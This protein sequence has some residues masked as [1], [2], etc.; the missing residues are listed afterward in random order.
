PQDDLRAVRGRPQAPG[1]EGVVHPADRR[2]DLLVR[3]VLDL[4]DQLAGG[5]VGD[6]VHGYA[7]LRSLTP[8]RLLYTVYSWRRSDH[9][10]RDAPSVPRSGDQLRAKEWRGWT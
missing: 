10:R 1:R 6:C 5:G 2:A 4:L 3:R 8:W 7:R 9:V